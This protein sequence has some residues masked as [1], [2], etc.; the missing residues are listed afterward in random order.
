MSKKQI[1]EINDLK[2][3]NKVL[4]EEIEQ[5]EDFIKKLLKSNNKPD[6]FLLTWFFVTVVYFFLKKLGRI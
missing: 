4:K 1:I 6:L 5:K 2:Y 3:K